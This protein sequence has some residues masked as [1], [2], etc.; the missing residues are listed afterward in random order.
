MPWIVIVWNDPI[1]LMS[2]VTWV[3]QKLFG[4]PRAKAEKLMWDVHT[5]GR[6]VVSNGTRTRPS[7]TWRA[8]TPRPV[9]DD[10]EG[11]LGEAAQGT[12][13]ADRPSAVRGSAVRA[14]ARR[15]PHDLRAAAAAAHVG[16]PLERSG[17]DA[18]VPPAL[19]EDD[20]LGNLEWEQQHGDELLLGKLEA[21][22]VVERTIDR[23]E[24]SDDEL[25]A[26]LGSLNSSGSSS[27]RGSA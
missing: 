23:H 25:L 5:K 2:Y 16:E 26:W 14:G 19:P 8:S 12:G 21:L 7:A 24:L 18:P 1:N 20:V 22:D 6:A 17:D 10:A 9:G 4:Y 3:F 13:T 15:G 27:A 11:P